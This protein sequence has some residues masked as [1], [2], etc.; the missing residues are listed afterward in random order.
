MRH[1]MKSHALLRSGTWQREI[2]LGSGDPLLLF[3]SLP[4]QTF[5]C[6]SFHIV[7]AVTATSWVNTR[8]LQCKKQRDLH[9]LRRE[10]S[11]TDD[12]LKVGNEFGG[13]AIKSAT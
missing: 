6:R 13:R 11:Y 9:T 4:A 3:F 7:M 12:L 1:N 5:K 2:V 8:P 10:H